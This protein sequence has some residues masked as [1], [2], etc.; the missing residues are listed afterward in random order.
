[1]VAKLGQAG[2]LVLGLMSIPF[3]V[4]FGAVLTREGR[5]FSGFVRLYF[6]PLVIGFA[7]FNFMAREFARRSTFGAA[8]F[9]CMVSFYLMAMMFM[10]MLRRL[11]N[12]T[13]REMGVGAFSKSGE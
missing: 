11:Q 3:A 13:E 2:A 5:P 4:W 1:M 6:R 9:V 10:P 8:D 12:K 7:L